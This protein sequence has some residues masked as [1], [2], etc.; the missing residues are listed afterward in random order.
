MLPLLAI[1]ILIAGKPITF[2]A[3]V[4]PFTVVVTTVAVMAIGVG[5]VLILVGILRRTFR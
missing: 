3:S 1:R 4:L 5:A 2:L